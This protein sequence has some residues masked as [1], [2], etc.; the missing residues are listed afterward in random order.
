MD[1][2][3]VFARWRQRALPC[4]H[5][6]AT[7]RIRL[8][9]CFLRPACVESKTQ[10]ANRSVQLFLHSL[11][12]KD[13][14]FCNGQPFPKNCPFPWGSGLP[15]DTRFLGPIQAHNPDGISIGSAVFADVCVTERPTDHA[16]RSVA[17]NLVYVRN[18]NIAVR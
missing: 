7:W 15:S 9:L 17:I 1:G 6:G 14:I 10:T 3:I 11:G 18:T 8:N 2:S 4:G 12:Q 5:I 13:P 16:S